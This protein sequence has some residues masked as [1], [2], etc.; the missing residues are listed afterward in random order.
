MPIIAGVPL[1][2]ED[3]QPAGPPVDPVRR[4][5][6]GYSPPLDRTGNINWTFREVERRPDWARR[7]VSVAN[8]KLR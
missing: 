6:S 3:E 4:R 8:W 1:P 7:A 5:F 2:G